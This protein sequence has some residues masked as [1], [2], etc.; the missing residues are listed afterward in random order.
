MT[1]PSP[2]TFLCDDRAIRGRY[3]AHQSDHR[4]RIRHTA[5]RGN[6]RHRGARVPVPRP[7]RIPRTL[8]WRYLRRRP[9]GEIMPFGLDL[10]SLVVGALLAMF[11]LPRLLG[12]FQSRNRTATA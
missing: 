9:I 10:M 12:L 4:G 2:V 1:L 11:V 3:P 6:S 5:V 8:C 7:P